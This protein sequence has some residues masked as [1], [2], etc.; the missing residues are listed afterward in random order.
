MLPYDM[1]PLI[2]CDD[3]ALK[4]AYIF[5]YMCSYWLMLLLF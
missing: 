1:P 4:Q 3:V 5:F 2:L